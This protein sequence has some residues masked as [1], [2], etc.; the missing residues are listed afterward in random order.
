ML[1]WL[2]NW[3]IEEDRQLITVGDTVDWT[4]YP[5]DRNWVRRLFADRLAIEWQIDNYGDAVSQPSRTASAEITELQSVR[6]RQLQT[7]TGIVPATGE[8]TLQPVTDTS[9]SWARRRTPHEHHA[10]VRSTG[11][12]RYA[13]SYT[14]AR[15]VPE[16]ESLYGYVAT[17]T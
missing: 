6:C 5:A 9:G 3:Q 12:F 10:T 16:A 11:S 2:T 17:L 4:L 15:H 1:V 8:A 7:S 13:A 14:S